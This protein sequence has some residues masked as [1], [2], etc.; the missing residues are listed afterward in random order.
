[1]RTVHALVAAFAAGSLHAQPHSPLPPSKPAPCPSAPASWRLSKQPVP[2][3]E[4]DRKLART[5]KG[6]EDYKKG[7]RTHD[8]IREFSDARTRGYAVY[9]GICVHAFFVTASK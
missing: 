3:E 8:I 9:R 6:W 4:V 1:M 5:H 2:F 7:R